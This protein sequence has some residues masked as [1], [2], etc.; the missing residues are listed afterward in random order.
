MQQDRYYNNGNS[1]AFWSNQNIKIKQI[2]FNSSLTFKK[3]LE[4]LTNIFFIKDVFCNQ[5]NVIEVLM[6]LIIGALTYGSKIKLFKNLKIIRNKFKLFKSI[7]S[8]TLNILKVVNIQSKTFFNPGRVPNPILSY[9]LVYQ[10]NA[11]ILKH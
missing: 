3:L 1:F 5:N 4:L 10:C 11:V 9:K 8:L 2:F 6:Y 7:C